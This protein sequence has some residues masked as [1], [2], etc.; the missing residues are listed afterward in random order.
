[1]IYT[2]ETDL[3]PGERAQKAEIHRILTGNGNP[4]KHAA[5]AAHVFEAGKY[6]G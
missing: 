1:M 3:T 5:D 4:E 2:I 6:I